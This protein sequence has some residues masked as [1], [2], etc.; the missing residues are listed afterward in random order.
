M[1]YKLSIL[2]ILHQQGH[3][4]SLEV[5][6]NEN[7]EQK[8]V[9]GIY[10]V[11]IGAIFFGESMF[12]RETNTS[13]LAFIA[14]ARHLQHWGYELLDAQVESPHLLTLGCRSIPRDDF[15]VILGSACPRKMAH[16]WEFIPDL[17]LF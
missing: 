8:L 6:R 13:K 14:L 4:H 11:S 10:G 16:A 15:S 2:S 12:S 17:P 9:G 3:A 7:D 5:W 1:T